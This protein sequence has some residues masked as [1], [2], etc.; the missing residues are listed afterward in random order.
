MD[1]VIFTVKIEKIPAE[2]EV[3]NDIIKCISGNTTHFEINRKNLRS[4]LHLKPNKILLNFTHQDLLH[5]ITISSKHTLS[6]LSA[7]DE[8]TKS[9]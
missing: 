7:L 6:V 9:K 2:L 1:K 3:D 5:Q 4:F 8:L